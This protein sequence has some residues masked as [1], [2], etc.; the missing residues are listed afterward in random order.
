MDSIL[1]KLFL[2]LFATN[3]IWQ[4]CKVMGQHRDHWSS[5]KIWLL[6]LTMSSS[7]LAVLELLKYFDL[8]SYFLI[9]KYQSV[10]LGLWS[11]ITLALISL[12][13]IREINLKKVKTLWRFPLIGLLI[14]YY[15]TLQQTLAVV[16]L[17]ELIIW[18][19]LLNGRKKL[20]FYFRN[21]IKSM[22]ALLSGMGLWLIMPEKKWLLFIIFGIYYYYRM[23][24]LQAV[25]V[26]QW[27]KSNAQ[28][29]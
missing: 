13:S 2:G 28:S 10:I 8:T 19:V 7:T 12:G 22:V 25:A 26:S 21:N 1:Y 11:F 6:I 20:R 4:A 17:V 14:G 18:A 16:L 24:S 3:Q 27:I 23:I 5:S 29:N 9:I 15:L